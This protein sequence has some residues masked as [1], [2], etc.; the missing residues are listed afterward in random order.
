MWSATTTATTTLETPGRWVDVPGASIPA[1]LALP[2]TLLVTYSATVYPDS[3]QPPVA[4]IDKSRPPGADDLVSFRVLVDGAPMRASGAS[5]GY[6]Q[7]ASSLVGGYLVVSLAA[8]NHTLELQWKKTGTFVT[9]WR[10]D[11]T[12]DTGFSG[13]CSLIAAA[14]HSYVWYTQPLYSIAMEPTAAYVSVPGMSLSVSLPTPTPLRFLYNLPLRPDAMPLTGVGSDI[15]RV[16]TILSINNVLNDAT[17]ATY[18]TQ[19]KFTQP[20]ALLSDVAL[21]LPAGEYSVQLLLRLQ[22]P[23][24]RSWRSLPTTGDG[25]LMGR[26][27]AVIAQAPTTIES[28]QVDTTVLSVPRTKWFDVGSAV[29]F[30]VVGAVTTVLLTYLLP[31]QMLNNPY[32]N[33]FSQFDAGAVSARLLV[34]SIPYTSSAARV[35]GAAR[36]NQIA[37]ASLAL[38]LFPGPHTVKLQ[39]MYQDGLEPGDI[40]TIMN[41]I[42]EGHESFSLRVHMDSWINTPTVVASAPVLLGHQNQA[43]R[44]PPDAIAVVDHTN[45]SFN[46]PIVVSCSVD[47]GTIALPPAPSTVTVS[48]PSATTTLLKGPLLDVN[49]VLSN[50]VY[51]PPT[52]WFGNATLTMAVQDQTMYLIEP[53]F[54]APTTVVVAMHYTP[55]APTITLPLGQTAIAEGATGAITGLRIVGDEVSYSV[56]GLVPQTIAVA[57][58]VASGLVSLSSTSNL[59]FARGSGRKDAMMHF[60]GSLQDVNRALAVLVYTPDDDFNSLQHAESLDVV[61]ENVASGLLATAAWPIT[62]TAVNDRPSIDVS[63]LQAQLQGYLVTY[64]DTAT[65]LYLRL[66]AF[67]EWG[68]LQLEA[69][70]GATVVTSS[71]RALRV[72][73]TSMSVSATMASLVYRRDVFYFGSEIISVEASTDAAFGVRHVTFLQLSMANASRIGTCECILSPALTLA[74]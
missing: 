11:P 69:A 51:T 35:A 29:P 58:R 18:S 57:L 27:L 10:I 54:P 1:F 34:D 15:D 23:S 49:R 12:V 66:Q 31:I 9:S 17:R 40:I 21:T 55:V 56:L 44:L 64:A 41:A 43:L 37:Q 22:S 52:N 4:I 36:G 72:S 62:V 45:T 48:T 13:A 14:Q 8:G 28:Y 74:E 60:T 42:T 33:S 38:Q 24:G 3:V 2:M 65:L 19:A 63:Q 7:G 26:L 71:A 61:V 53:T 47:H 16:D 73:G 30:N 6:Y 70:P 68:Q 50:I 39:W 32:F 46:Y 59:S 5:S 25:F 20:N 67:S